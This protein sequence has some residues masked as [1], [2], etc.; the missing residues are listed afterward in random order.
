MQVS[1][2]R[3]QTRWWKLYVL[4]HDASYFDFESTFAKRPS[5]NAI[6]IPRQQLAALLEA[7]N[8]S[9]DTV[10]HMFRLAGTL[11][12]RV[13]NKV[14][15]RETQIVPF[16]HSCQGSSSIVNGKSA[17]VDEGEEGWDTD[18]DLVPAHE[19]QRTAK[20]SYMDRQYPAGR[21]L[22]T[23]LCSLGANARKSH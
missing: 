11:N 8:M 19:D 16:G 10:A 18:S 4:I 12:M 3:N 6:S 2:H 7:Y 23:H 1:V 17:N 13:S 20:L 22:G 21:V 15:A 5:Q 9:S 14:Q